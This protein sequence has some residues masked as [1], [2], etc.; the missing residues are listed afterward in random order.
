[1]LLD[2]PNCL[3]RYRGG[4]RRAAS[5]AAFLAGS[6]TDGLIRTSADWRAVFRARITT[7]GL[8]HLDVDQI[9]GLP[10]GYCNK[11]LNSKKNPTTV[12]IARICDALA[13]AFVPVVDADR[14]AIVRSQWS[15]R[16]R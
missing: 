12:T 7:L 10:D 8:S 2:W 4:P 15:K 11:I 9:A 16:Q 6:M 13:L 3:G 14:E 1:M 5:Q